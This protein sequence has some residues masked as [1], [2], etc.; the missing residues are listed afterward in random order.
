MTDA[1]CKTCP[2]FVDRLW[3]E[4]SLGKGEGWCHRNPE[5]YRIRN[6]AEHWC[7]DHPKRKRREA[8]DA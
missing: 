1:T 2:F 5:P 3:L 4:W 8:T 7:G 6:A